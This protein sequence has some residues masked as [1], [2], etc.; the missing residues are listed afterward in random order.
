M[1]L[2]LAI[3]VMGWTGAALLLLAYGMVSS[4]RWR[5]GAFKFQ[6]LNII[7]SVLLIANTVYYG[8]FPSAVVNAVWIGIALFTLAKAS[9]LSETTPST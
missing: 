3:D 6:L 7:G 8:A 1:T 2:H 5:G 4:E 9:R